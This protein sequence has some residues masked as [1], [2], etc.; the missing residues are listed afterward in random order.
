MNRTAN[1]SAIG[2][3]VVVH[4]VL[5]GALGTI[6]IALDDKLP[7][8]VLETVFDDERQQEE[9][10]KPLETE[11]EI[12]ETQNLIAG[13]AVSTLVGG[14]GA[15]AVAQ[16]KVE[17]SESLQEVDF[18]VNPSA[19]D[20]PGENLIGQDLGVGEVN[21]EVGAM[22]E[23]YGA[24]LSRMTQEL[25]RMM[26]TEK[27]M[28]VWL[29]DES[30]S[31]KDDQ[32][33][34]AQK[35]HKIYEEL[36]IQSRKDKNLKDRD[37]VL[38]TSICSFGKAVRELTKK[39]TTDVNE[40]RQAI[41]KIPVDESG[42]ENMFSAILEVTKNFGPKARSQKRR[43]VVIVISDE[44]PSDAGDTSLSDYGQIEQAIQACE[45]A[46]APVYCMGR[47]AIFGYPFARIRWKD[48][49]YQLNHWVWINRGPETAYPEALQWDGLHARHD[50][51]P[52]GFGPYSQV[53]LCKETGGV[54]FMLPGEEENLVGRPAA[55]EAR[56]F[57]ALAMKEYEP[58]LLSRRDYEEQRT[59]SKFRTGVWDV[60]KNLNP[61][62]DKKLNM[63]TWHFAV[64]PEE[65]QKQGGQE[66]EKAAYAMSQLN[67]GIGLM[68][69][70]RP[71]RA[72]E[73]SQRW[74][75]AYDLIYAQCLAYR[76]RLFQYLLVL[77]DHSASGRK[78][79]D[80]KHNRWDIHN[81]K[82]Y[83]EPTDKQFDRIKSAFKIKESRSDYLALLK[84]EMQKADEA[85]DSVVKEHAGTPW[86][87]RSKWDKGRRYG[88]RFDSM[89]WDPR[90]NEVGKRIK[91]P[92]F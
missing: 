71:L 76:V 20:L 91:V 28:A 45:K 48:P 18:N 37:E 44:S 8:I 57:H 54:Y 33:E 59:R 69:N 73:D 29:F 92:K 66:F 36:G 22:V 3:S 80:P 2:T 19:I 32:Q 13:G 23:G 81:N 26:R 11:T 46:K 9:F 6:T 10:T 67:K 79:K 12:A 65:F 84:S 16:Q 24:A 47:E 49:V 58:L 41:D 52:S 31:M 21:G 25:I 42:D 88:Y 4:L 87:A 86:D 43:L 55:I 62:W 72:K 17:T 64:E 27:V 56:K 74:R 82:E 63:R 61:H 53:R 77:D 39:P 34:I 5:I 30:N 68:D 89:F 38:L 60:I 75:A 51:S 70:I 90:Y 83:M 40:I 15:P 85:F 35:F 14:S 50:S 7:E 78:P 1:Y